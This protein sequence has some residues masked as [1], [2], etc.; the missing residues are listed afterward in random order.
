MEGVLHDHQIILERRRQ[1]VSKCHQRGRYLS[2]T[3][4]RMSK[5]HFGSKLYHLATTLS[6]R[7]SQQRSGG[8]GR[9]E[10]VQVRPTRRPL[11]G[12]LWLGHFLSVYCWVCRKR[13]RSH[14][15]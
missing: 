8:S 5:S 9:I 3:G 6:D 12:T 7:R 4:K 14:L 1:A 13:V 15:I 2:R 10:N 11:A